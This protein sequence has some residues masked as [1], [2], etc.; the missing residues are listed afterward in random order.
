MKKLQDTYRPEYWY[1]A[2][3]GRCME[4]EGRDHTAVDRLQARREAVLGLP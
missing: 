2:D 4:L 3:T 1:L